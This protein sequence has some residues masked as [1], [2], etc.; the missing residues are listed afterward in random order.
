MPK[1]INE[2]LRPSLGATNRAV[3]EFL[4]TP[5]IEDFSSYVRESGLDSAT[6]FIDS[7]LFPL[8][9]VNRDQR[10]SLELLLKVAQKDVLGLYI[11]MREYLQE[12]GVAKEEVLSTIQRSTKLGRQFGSLTNTDAYANGIAEAAYERRDEFF[13]LDT[14]AQGEKIVRF[15]SPALEE[16]KG[17]RGSEI[18]CPVLSMSVYCPHTDDKVSVYE[19]YWETFADIAA[20]KLAEE[21]I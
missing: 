8:G 14:D 17:F 10:D 11:G 9:E 13:A 3:K 1:P 7:G 4:K 12:Q 18:G 20:H 5:G 6:G 2:E 16:F 19:L 21:E 15:T